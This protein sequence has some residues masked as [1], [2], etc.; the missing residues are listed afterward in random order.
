MGG[1]TLGENMKGVIAVTPQEKYD[2]LSCSN[3]SVFLL[4]KGH[5]LFID[6]E[7]A[8]N[9]PLINNDYELTRQITNESSRFMPHLVELIEV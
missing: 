1:D 7:K 6:S 2:I 8:Y 5:R 3:S 4:H 9:C